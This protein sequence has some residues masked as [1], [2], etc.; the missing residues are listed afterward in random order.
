MLLTLF[1]NWLLVLP[2]LDI[3]IAA[4]YIFD[5]C[6]NRIQANAEEMIHLAKVRDTL[7]PKLLSGEVR[8]KNAEQLAKVL[9]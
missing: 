8:V 2:T 4:S 7:M 5:A 6:I 1:T 3:Q 9:V